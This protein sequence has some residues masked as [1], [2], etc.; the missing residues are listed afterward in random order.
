[1]ASTGRGGN[2]PCSR[3]DGDG[4]YTEIMRVSRQVHQESSD[5][6]YGAVAMEM[7]I[8]VRGMLF[9]N[10]SCGVWGVDIAP[11]NTV[12]AY[13]QRFRKLALRIIGYPLDTYENLALL[14]WKT[15]P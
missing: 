13:I 6:L 8:D 3:K 4:C 1:M 15:Y 5:Q 12:E 2:K 9:L 10:R 7:K 14:F 11:M